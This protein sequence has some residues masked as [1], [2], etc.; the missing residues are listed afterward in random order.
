[1]RPCSV[2]TILITH[3]SGEYTD[4]KDALTQGQTT[5]GVCII[6]PNHQPTFQVYCGMD[7][8]GDGWTVFQYREDGSVDRHW[9]DYQR[10][11]GNQQVESSG[12]DW[13]R[14]TV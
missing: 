13:R 14:Y 2:L 3:H 11:F 5:S 9:T 10:G 4:C 12:W 7:T 1:V 6:K 8:D